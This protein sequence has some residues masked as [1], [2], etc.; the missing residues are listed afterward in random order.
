VAPKQKRKPRKRNKPFVPANKVMTEEVVRTVIAMVRDGRTVESAARGFGVTEEAFYGAARR[1]GLSEEH[2]KARREAR[3]A[4]GVEVTVRALDVIRTRIEAGEPR[5]AAWWLT[6]F[7]DLSLLPTRREAPADA[8]ATP[9]GNGNHGV[10]AGG[11]RFAV[12]V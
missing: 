2:A 1:M 8:S 9:T 10:S 12:A 7:G 5:W 4:L 3:A 6:N 11:I